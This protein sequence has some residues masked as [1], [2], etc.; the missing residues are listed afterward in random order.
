MFLESLFLFRWITTLFAVKNFFSFNIFFDLVFHHLWGGARF[1]YLT[2]VE[3]RFFIEIVFILHLFYCLSFV[4][5]NFHFIFKLR[6]F[7][8]KAW[9]TFSSWSRFLFSNLLFNSFTSFSRIYTLSFN[10]SFSL[11]L[12]LLSWVYSQSSL[13]LHSFS[14]ENLLH[15][16]GCLFWHFITSVHLERSSH[17]SVKCFLL[18]PLLNLQKPNFA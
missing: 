14:K 7:R 10:T 1:F 13:N 15:I 5:H 6:T 18:Q 3:W 16:L 12:L 11:S 2:I 9:T 17:T 4:P 8:V